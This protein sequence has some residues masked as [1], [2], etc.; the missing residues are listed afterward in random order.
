M[1]DPV[2]VV[3]N[4]AAGRGRA[5]RLLPDIRAVLDNRKI[6]HTVSISA[7]PGE[8]ET[9]ARE[10]SAA[11]APAVIAV[12]GDGLAGMVANGLTGTPTPLALVPGGTGDDFARALG[13]SRRRPLEVLDLLTPDPRPRVIDLG[14]V[15][16]AHLR[17]YFV[18]V[19]S[20]GFDAE[21]AA[22]ANEIGRGGRAKYVL[23]LVKTLRRF[24]PLTLDVTVDGTHSS[25]SAMLI[26]IGNGPTYGGGMRVTP[27][28]RIDDGELEACIVR[29]L[30]TARFLSTF[31]RVYRGT[32]VRHPKV[33]M[34]HGGRFEIEADR[35][36]PVFADGE[37]VGELPAIVEIVPEALR[38][39]SP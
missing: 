37:A 11:G 9:F 15:S 36:T 33:T 21:V 2:R 20:A 26:A 14:R 18:A 28:A 31:P 6:D 19:A 38:V 16:T 8:P 34:L 12:G 1:H 39:L 29:S 35:P 24:R 17:R 32:H 23:A 5:L 13:L 10:A 3:V 4:P 30:G 7:G 22:A 27:G 25:S